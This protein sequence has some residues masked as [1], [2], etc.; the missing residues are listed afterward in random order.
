MLLDRQTSNRH[1]DVAMSFTRIYLAATRNERPLQRRVRDYHPVRHEVCD[2]G[3]APSIQEVKT[4]NPI[5]QAPVSPDDQPQT[6]SSLSWLSRTS[7]LMSGRD[8]TSI[9]LELFT[10]GENGEPFQLQTGRFAEELGVYEVTVRATLYKMQ[11]ARLLQVADIAGPTP[12]VRLLIEP[13]VPARSRDDVGTTR[14]DKNAPGDESIG[15]VGE[16]AVSSVTDAPDSTS[17]PRR[18]TRTTSCCST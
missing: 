14:G 7:A 6:M 5:K 15:T 13:V 17:R 1:L 9:A 18:S 12:R 3:C 16:D 8:S 10:M 11:Q 2:L 4:M